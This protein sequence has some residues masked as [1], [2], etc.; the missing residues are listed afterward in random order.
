MIDEAIGAFQLQPV[1]QGQVEVRADQGR[2]ELA[3]DLPGVEL[4]AD[5]GDGLA[6]T[7]AKARRL[8]RREGRLFLAVFQT[9]HE[10]QRPGGQLEQVA[11]QIGQDVRLAHL[12]VLTIFLGQIGAGL[13]ADAARSEQVD[14]H[15]AGRVGIGRSRQV[16]GA[17]DLVRAVARGVQGIAEAL[18]IDA[19]GAEIA[20]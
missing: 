4:P 5:R 11:A 19:G 13:V 9:D 18:L 7:E 6:A 14:G 17:D 16:G 8:V 2:Q 10:A 20:F 1:D 15:A 12:E 3:V